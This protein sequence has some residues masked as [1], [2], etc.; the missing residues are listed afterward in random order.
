MENKQTY[1]RENPD[2]LIVACSGVS[3]VGEISDLAA[4]KLSKQ[5]IGRMFCVLRVDN[6]KKGAIEKA[7]GWN[8]QDK[9]IVF[10]LTGNDENLNI[11]SENEGA[12]L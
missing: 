6:N 12:A 8:G 9:T 1:S 5:G 2:T 7:K 10:L 4:R 3:D 11:Y